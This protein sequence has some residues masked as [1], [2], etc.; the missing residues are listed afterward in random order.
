MLC[1][2]G[3]PVIEGSEI[4]VNLWVLSYGNCSIQI[5]FICNFGTRKAHK[6]VRPGCGSTQ[7]KKKYMREILMFL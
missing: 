5:Y 6:E 2:C 3:R 1:D 4:Q 7:N